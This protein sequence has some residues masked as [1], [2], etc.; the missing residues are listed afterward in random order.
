MF[1]YLDEYI[2]RVILARPSVA[3]HDS[4]GKQRWLGSWHNQLNENAWPGPKIVK[5]NSLLQYIYNENVA[6]QSQKYSMNMLIN[7]VKILKF[8]DVRAQKFPRTDFFLNLP[9]RKVMIYYCQKGQ[10]N[11]DH[12]RRFGENM[13]RK[14]P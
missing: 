13:P 7:K 8:K 12:R 10:K 5:K 6:V 14:I 1:L 4:E 9:C 3:G 2:V 11:G